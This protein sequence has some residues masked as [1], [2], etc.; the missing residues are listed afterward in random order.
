M[1][2]FD[3]MESSSKAA[4]EK[5]V[6]GG[7]RI[8]D[9]GIYPTRIEHAYQV[10]SPGGALGIALS[11]VTP[12]GQKL[13]KTTYISTKAGKTFYVKDGKEHH[14]PGFSLMTALATLVADK[15]LAELETEDK[16]VKIFDFNTRA[17][18]P[19]TVPM[20]TELV[21][22]E[23]YTGIVRQIVDKTVKSD[24]G[25]YVPT[26]DTREENEIGKFF[27]AETKQT[28]SE[29]KAGDAEAEFFGKWADKFTGE[30]LNKAKG[31]AGNAGAPKAAGGD[32]K[33]KKSL[34]D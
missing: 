32:S 26:G 29:K 22:K 11:L 34:F 28:A 19:T 24:D 2:L 10:K 5:D 13:N 31:A 18:V 12:E 25:S 20:L 23:V 17:E 33:P 8:M 4:E 15:S 1:S 9:S 27:D 7:S 3:G 30:V 16:V 14:L 6:L 21:G